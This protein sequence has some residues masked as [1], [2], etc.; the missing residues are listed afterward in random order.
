MRVRPLR[1]GV[2]CAL[3]A[4]GLKSPCRHWAKE[5][6]IEALISDFLRRGR[7]PQE[8]EWAASNDE[9]PHSSS[10][11]RVFGSWVRAREA[12][13]QAF[14]ASQ[15]LAWRSSQPRAEPAA[16]VTPQPRLR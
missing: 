14:E 10:V 3:A 7:W 11:R 8:R 15:W 9:H 4:A 6:M 16:W 13:R 2:V 5:A 1:V 12:A